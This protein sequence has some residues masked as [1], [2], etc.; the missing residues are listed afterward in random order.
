MNLK[1]PL[2]DWMQQHQAQIE[3]ALDKRLTM[4]K[5]P[6]SQRLVEAMRYAT[7]G[8]GKRLRA[9]LVYATGEA[10]GANLSLIHI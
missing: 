9:L 6:G 4:Q 10:M 2:E 3:L 5:Q 1:F 7:L 8:G